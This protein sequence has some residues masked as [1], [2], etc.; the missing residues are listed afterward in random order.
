M[1]V[2]KANELD[3]SVREMLESA[4]KEDVL[5]RRKGKAPVLIHAVSEEDLEDYLLESDSRFMR[6]IEA[7]RKSYRKHGGKPIEQVA[8]ELGIQLS[9]PKKAQR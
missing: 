1:K 8:K 9:N 3:R 4:A 7:R 5:V 6:L 2:I